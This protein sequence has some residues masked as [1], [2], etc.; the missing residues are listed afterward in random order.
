[1]NNNYDR[2]AGFYDS[3]SK[4]V[5]GNAL[6]QA[7]RSMLHKIPAHSKILIVG[8]GTGA[9]ME[10]IAKLHPAGLSITYV[11]I[12]EKMTALARQRNVGQ[13]RV[14]F[15]HAAIEDYRTDRTFDVIITA[16][17]FDNFK[18]EKAELVFN[19]LNKLLSVKGHWL[20]ADFYIDPKKLWQKW[21][22]RSMY[23]FFNIL[24]NVE[25]N[26]LPE[27]ETLFH[28]N[29]YQ[30][31]FQQFSFGRFIHSNVYQKP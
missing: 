20:L 4:L 22:L 16:F 31:V 5:F 11:E 14:E 30:T 6:M 21:L 17:L 8:G 7:Q 15:V 25:T 29:G 27:T 18:Q 19:V 24:S 10:E 13:N 26:Q 28:A 23:L 1:M 3:L 9:M 12:S 2:V